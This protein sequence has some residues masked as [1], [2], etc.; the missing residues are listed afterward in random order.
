MYPVT[1]ILENG[2]TSVAI[3]KADLV[4]MIETN[5]VIGYEYPL[6]IIDG[7]GI[8]ITI[9]NEQELADEDCKGGASYFVG[10]KEYCHCDKLFILYPVS[11]IDQDGTIT[12]IG[13][14]PELLA[15]YEAWY[16]IS[17]PF[18][19]FFD[20]IYP[21]TCVDIDGVETDVNNSTDLVYLVNET[22]Y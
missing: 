6:Q 2:T 22:C 4:L 18:D 3:C 10:V 19:D 13:D 9:N 17:N 16:A 11:V 12:P 15:A 7:N 5:L 21:I 8:D 14:Y 20:F 1:A